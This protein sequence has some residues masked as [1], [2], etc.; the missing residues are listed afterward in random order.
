MVGVKIV[1]LMLLLTFLW[2]VLLIS[3]CRKNPYTYEYW[4]TRRAGPPFV[5]WGWC[6]LILLD[7]GGIMYIAFYFLFLR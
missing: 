6:L 4:K 5:L 1:L 7:M 3:Y 2:G